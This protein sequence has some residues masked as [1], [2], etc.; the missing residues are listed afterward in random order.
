MVYS[1]R[2]RANGYRN[3]QIKTKRVVLNEKVENMFRHKIGHARLY[4]F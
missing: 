4:F 3:G 2:I 1:A